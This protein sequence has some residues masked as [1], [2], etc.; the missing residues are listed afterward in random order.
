L[1]VKDDGRGLDL[2]TIRQVAKHRGLYDEASL[3][4]MTPIQL[5]QLIFSPGFSTMTYVTELSGR[6]VGLDVVR[7]N[8]ERMKGEITLQSSAGQG[9]TVRLHLPL[10]LATTRLLLA[11]VGDGLFG[12]PVECIHSSRRLHQAEN[13]TLE[14]RSAVLLDGQAV[15]I[16]RL[17]DLL[18]C[19]AR[20][21][22]LEPDKMPCI[23]IQ[24]GEER[25]GLLADDLLSEQEVVPKPLGP[26]LRRV[27]NVSA[28]AMLGN[29]EICPVLNPSDLI[30]SAHKLSCNSVT[31][32]ETGAQQS[33]PVVLLV[34]DSALIRAMEKRIL[35]D[36]GYE[37]VTA[38]DG[39]DALNLL[40][41]RGFAAVVSDIMMPN[42]DGLT[43]TSRIRATPGQQALPVILVTSLASDADKRRGLE[44][45]ANAYI[46]KPSFDQRL[47]LDTLKRLVL[48]WFVC[49][50]LTTRPS[51]C[52]SCKVCWRSHPKSR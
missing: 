25:L 35:E 48:T 45:G 15:I 5:Q 10:S 52:I 49:C 34:E 32:V 9:L 27:R 42:M 44:V 41:T 46:P 36:G 24:V 3:A 43:L 16:A 17:A 11:R 20:P 6:G 39:M 8:V 40:G 18:E 23:F 38:V 30:R 1:E 47:L 7:V 50:W 51:R 28:L 4:G 26:P 31:H 2:D 37:V 19:A 21:P 22:E 12:L 29:G 33:N 14:G 13:F